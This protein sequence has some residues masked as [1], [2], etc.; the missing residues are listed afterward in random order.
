M[1]GPARSIG[2][3]RGRGRQYTPPQTSWDQKERSQGGE[4]F[5]NRSKPRP[6]NN[7]EPKM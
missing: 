1:H 2:A 4:E 7:S 5:L 3:N 6:A